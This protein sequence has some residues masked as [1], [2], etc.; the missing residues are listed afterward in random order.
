[1]QSL[2]Q[3]PH[4]DLESYLGLKRGVW[5]TNEFCRKISEE[6]MSHEVKQI[7][8]AYRKQQVVREQC[9]GDQVNSGFGLFISDMR[10][11]SKPMIRN[12]RK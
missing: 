5:P 7:V 2:L 1:M 3:Y 11:A 9:F 8:D 10:A 12:V 4:L 6:N